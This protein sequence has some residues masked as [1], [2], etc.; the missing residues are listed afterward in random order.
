MSAT[1]NRQIKSEYQPP[2][3]PTFTVGK[4]PTLAAASAVD[5][6]T[7]AAVTLATS[8]AVVVV[9]NCGLSDY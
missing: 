9:G 2:T 1:S 6:A 3:A 5:P 4:P 7:A 8:S